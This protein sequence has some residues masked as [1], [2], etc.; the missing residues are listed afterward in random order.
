[1]LHISVNRYMKIISLFVFF[2]L[3]CSCTVYT[4]KQ[5]Q[6]LSRAVYAARD[7]FDK[8][9]IDL[10]TT[11]SSEAA[12]IV[13]PP[14]TKI[15]ITPIYKTV[16]IP[17]VASSAK[18]KVPV[19][20]SKQRV[21]VIPAEYKND[22]VV[23]VNSEEYQQLL[24]DKETFEQLKKDYEQTLKFKSE[25]DDELARQEAYANKMIQDLNRMQKQ[26]VEKDLAIL[27]RNIIIAILLLTIG[28]ATYL[29]I[30]GIL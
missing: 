14:K 1:M 24:K 23:V 19:Q 22:T 15:Q 5:S 11:Y 28:G 10:A 21:L 13:K 8:A 20:V 18:P 17:V 16:T 26:L 4:E 9:R 29:R 2:L 27:K 12:R 6:A 7:S 3:L 25:V 30:K